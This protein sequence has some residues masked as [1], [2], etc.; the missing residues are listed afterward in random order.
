M[1]CARENL[2]NVHT[3]STDKR[4]PVNRLPV[5]KAGDLPFCCTAVREDRTDQCHGINGLLR[6]LVTLYG[7]VPG[8]TVLIR[9]TQRPFTVAGSRG[10]PAI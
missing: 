10:T 6:K 3:H 9:K 1:S 2:T 8:G 4:E 5:R 7:V